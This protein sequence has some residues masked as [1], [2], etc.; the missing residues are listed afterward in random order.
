MLL[1]ELQKKQSKLGSGQSFVPG[2]GLPAPPLGSTPG[3]APGP[4]KLPGQG[5][6]LPPGS[7]GTFGGT[8]GNGS[9][10]TLPGFSGPNP[11]SLQPPGHALFGAPL[12]PGGQSAPAAT[13]GGSG[14]PSAGFRQP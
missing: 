5:F 11:S 3:K 10:G 9:L 13:P 6:G 7:S 2:S 8:L 1:K 12:Q 4:A 14:A